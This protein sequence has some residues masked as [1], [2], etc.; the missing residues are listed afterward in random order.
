MQ[1][2]KSKWIP[3][4]TVPEVDEQL[5]NETHLDNMAK[6]QTSKKTPAHKDVLSLLNLA[7]DTAALAT[8]RSHWSSGPAGR[9]AYKTVNEK[10]LSQGVELT[11]N[12]HGQI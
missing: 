4:A 12:S 5:T 2:L 1:L 9:A 8:P 3:V 6:G 7:M 11:M 10:A